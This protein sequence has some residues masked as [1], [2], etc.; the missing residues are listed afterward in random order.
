MKG[1]AIL[2]L[3]VVF[4]CFVWPSIARWLKRKAIERTEDYILKSMGFP[5]R[6]KKKRKQESSDDPLGNQY[7]SQHRRRQ[8]RRYS[9]P[10][11]PPEYA[12]DVE[13]VEYIDY[14]GM[15]Y[16]QRISRHVDIYFESQISDAEW[17]EIKKPRSK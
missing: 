14:S 10:I 1:F 2:L 11:I 17:S 5:P 9:G 4:L 8:Y 7:Y 13:F 16:L 12:E 15:E 6:D 3:I